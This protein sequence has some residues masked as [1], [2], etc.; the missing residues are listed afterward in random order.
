[1]MG[2]MWDVMRGMWDVMGGIWDVMG[3]MWGVMGGVWDPHSPSEP[4]G[5]RNHGKHI[6]FTQSALLMQK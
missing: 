1:M 4:R 5:A 6:I 2:G 3:G